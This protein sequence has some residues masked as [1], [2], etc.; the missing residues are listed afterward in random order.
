MLRPCDTKMHI[1]LVFVL[2]GIAI[3]GY[4]AGYP[5]ESN[6]DCHD[7][8]YNGITRNRKKFMSGYVLGGVCRCTN[9]C[10]WALRYYSGM[11]PDEAC[12]S[13]CRHKYHSRATGECEN[14][15]LCHCDRSGRG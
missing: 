6:E 9:N 12:Q 13:F 10:Y 1:S 7:R 8:C 3:L 5:G 4:A 15:K 11:S 2:L 14:D